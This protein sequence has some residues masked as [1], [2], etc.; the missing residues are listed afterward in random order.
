MIRFPPRNVLLL[1][2][3]APGLVWSCGSTRPVREVVN[4][5]GE[6]VRVEAAEE[7]APAVDD[8]TLAQRMSDYNARRRESERAS[9]SQRATTPVP[10]S[11]ADAIE[12]PSP[13]TE[14]EEGDEPVGPAVLADRMTAYSHSGST[15][16]LTLDALS[17]GPRPPPAT[18]TTV[19]GYDPFVDRGCPP[20]GTAKSLKNQ[21]QNQLKNRISTPQTG[22]IDQEVTFSKL[23]EPG[24]DTNRWPSG[25]AATI[26]GYCRFAQGTQGETCNCGKTA[27][28]LVDT[29]FEIVSGPNDNGHP[30]IAEVTPVWRYIHK[31]FGLENWSSKA[32]GAKYEGHRVRITGW[33]FFDEIHASQADNTHP[34]DPQHNNWRATCWEIH[35]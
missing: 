33:L 24:D 4:E 18:G 35:S 23:R 10:E 13:A 22:D 31:H 2:L 1:A 20:I 21:K 3:V 32:L 19:A 30:F 26:E 8:Q 7:A 28:K 11:E 29:H 27:A 12:S 6:T 17:P 34:N 5:D 16:S 9:E 25:L 15:T 14:V